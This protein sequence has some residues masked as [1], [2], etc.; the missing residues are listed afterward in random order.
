MRDTAKPRRQVE[1]LGAKEESL[2]TAPKASGVAQQ[3]KKRRCNFT[4]TPI[5]RYGLVLPPRTLFDIV[6]VSTA[7][8]GALEDDLDSV[9]GSSAAASR[10]QA[11]TPSS[12]PFAVFGNLGTTEA[13]Q[14]P[15]QHSSLDGDFL[16]DLTSSPGL[17]ALKQASLCL[18][19][20]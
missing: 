15:S 17:S 8:S 13:A 6:A 7:Y 14:S 1:E 19:N 12:D 20:S 18:W 10:K 4:A 16:S 2:R 3:Q 11:A 9:F 5:Y